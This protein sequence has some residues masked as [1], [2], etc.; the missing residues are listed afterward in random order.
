MAARSK[1]LNVLNLPWVAF[2]LRSSLTMIQ[3]D[4]CQ[5]DDNMKNKSA[6]DEYL[7][8]EKLLLHHEPPCYI[9]IFIKKL[10]NSKSC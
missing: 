6:A 2:M 1:C 10:K 4:M 8:G 5:Q 3:N 7:L 9:I